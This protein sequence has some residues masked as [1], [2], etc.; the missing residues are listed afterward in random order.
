MVL[1]SEL[2]EEQAFCNE[3]EASKC[4]AELMVKEAGFDSVTVYRPAIIVGDSETG[5]TSTFHGLYA[6]LKSLAAIFALIRDGKFDA[7]AGTDLPVSMLMRSLGLTGQERKHFVPVQ[8]VSGSIVSLYDRPE[9][10]GGTYHL[11]GTNPV[12]VDETAKAMQNAFVR[13]FGES[14]ND[15]LRVELERSTPHSDTVL[16]DSIGQSFAAQLEAYKNYWRDDPR[17]DDRR[18]KAWLPDYPCPILD[19]PVLEK[20]CLFALRS[21]FGWPKKPVA[22]FEKS[23]AKWLHDHMVHS[24]DTSPDD[25]SRTIPI[26]QLRS[27]G[28]GGGE[29]VISKRLGLD[30]RL[31]NFES[32][33]GV[34]EQLSK[35]TF[36][37]ADLNKTDRLESLIDD[38]RAIVQ[39][40]SESEAS[41][42]MI[43]E[44]FQWMKSSLTT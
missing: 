8:W 17:F 28:M 40:A 19:L 29:Y 27:F 36:N 44:W 30:G 22:R 37:Q 33:P 34:Q 26:L 35:I 39:L 31:L 14:T 18:R 25:C 4:A 43:E 38:G 12:S 2:D 10:H 21:N 13:F 32:I 9:T 1:E 20:L 7:A 41:S 5:Y 23:T 3:Y 11:T 15:K 16:L 42:R 6:P 24:M